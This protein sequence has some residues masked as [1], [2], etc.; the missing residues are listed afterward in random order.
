VGNFSI[1]IKDHRATNI[2]FDSVK[3]L[4]EQTRPFDKEFEG[5]NKKNQPAKVE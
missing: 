1:F 2:Y 4:S 3:S 5:I